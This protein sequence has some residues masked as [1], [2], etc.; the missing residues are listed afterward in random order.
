MKNK[1]SNNLVI[2]EQASSWPYITSVNFGIPM[3]YIHA[4]KK[5]QKTEKAVFCN[6]TFHRQ[7]R[8]GFLCSLSEM[9]TIMILI[10]AVAIS[11]RCWYQA[12]YS[13]T[14]LSAA[15]WQSSSTACLFFL[16]FPSSNIGLWF[17]IY[18]RYDELWWINKVNMCLARYSPRASTTNQPTKRAPNEPSRP[19]PKWTKMPILGQIWSF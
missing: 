15:N 1:R 19:G 16:F 17:T 6:I 9:K 18:Y 5:T 13:F 10:K 14:P 12:I 2:L 4:F 8:H 7:W 11:L 3:H